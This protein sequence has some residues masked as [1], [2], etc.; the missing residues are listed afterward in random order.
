MNGYALANAGVMSNVP[1]P[2]LSE[3]VVQPNPPT[4]GLEGLRSL[5][6][7]T[8]QIWPVAADHVHRDATRSVLRDLGAPQDDVQHAYRLGSR[9][10]LAIESDRAGHLLLLDEGTSGK[11]Y[12]LCPSAFA[13]ETQLTAG[14]TYLPQRTSRYDAFVVSGQPGREHL[15]AILT[16]EPLEPDWMPRDPKREPARVV[17]AADIEMLLVRLQAVATAVP[18]S[19]RKC[20]GL[21]CSRSWPQK[22]SQS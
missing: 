5:A 12:C 7:F 14:R 15:L 10:S 13:P 19:I 17:S 21:P 8:D 16:E 2:V 20:E 18:W 4:Q 6:R 9:V 1:I 3:S 22:S 11:T